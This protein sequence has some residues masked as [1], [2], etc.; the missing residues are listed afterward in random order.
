VATKRVGSTSIETQW[1]AEPVDVPRYLT[2]LKRGRALIVAIVLLMTIAVFVLSTMLPKTYEASARLVMDDRPSGTEPADSETVTRRLATVRALIT[3]REVRG[4]AAARLDGESAETLEDKLAATADQEANIV[5]VH[6]TDND[7]VGAAAIANTVARTFVSMQRGAEQQRLARVR[8]ELERALA[9]VQSPASAEALALRE[10]LSELSVTEASAGPGLI[11]AEPAQPPKDP[12]SPRPVRNTI[13]AFFAAIFLAVLAALG[14][15]QLAPRLTGARE[16]SLLTGTP[17]LAVLPRSRRQRLD[18]HSEDDAYQELQT[19]LALQLPTESKI[20]VV[21][22]AL[23]EDDPSEVSA[24]LA[25]RFAQSRRRTLLLSADLRRSRA[26]EVLGLARS[27]G[28]VELLETS[29]GAALSLDALEPGL[30]SVDVDGSQLDVVTS[31]EPV[32]NA[33]GLLISERFSELLLEL[34]CSDYDHVVIEGPPLLGSVHG[35]LVA[36]HADALLVVSDPERL[37]PSEAVELGELIQRLDP[38]VAGFVA[39]GARGVGPYP[40][41]VTSPRRVPAGRADG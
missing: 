40:V 2:S 5:E 21:A 3:T 8:R 28:L 38:A 35:Q 20:A 11:V 39:M 37:S 30:H 26:H 13:F 34:E 23:P 12:S 36:R 4:R 27:P 14:L 25:R 41:A 29:S 22:G 1:D 18:G 19:T 7:A 16:L 15:G 17:V 9:R 10:R 32:K 24:G 6:A 33:A 31:G